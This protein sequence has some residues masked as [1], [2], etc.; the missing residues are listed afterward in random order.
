MHIHLSPRV[1][2]GILALTVAVTLTLA[3]CG[4]GSSS[5]PTSPSPVPSTPPP[6][7]T[8]P[9]PTGG[10][11][12]TVTV[13]FNQDVSPLLQADCARCHSG[14]RPEGNFSVTSYASVMRA[15]VAGSANSTLVRETR[16]GGGMYGN[17]SGNAAAKAETIRAW[18]VDN[19]AAE[20]R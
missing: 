6:T 3:G 13:S 7:S 12:S 16:Q 14:S 18:V 19:R 8:T 20:S 15:V 4:G 10:G 17:W 2:V 1:S 11:S 9:P 5:T